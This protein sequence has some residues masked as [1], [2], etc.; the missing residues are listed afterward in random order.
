MTETEVISVKPFP[1]LSQEVNRKAYE[2][3]EKAVT[4][5]GSKKITAVTYAYALRT[6]FDSFSGLADENFINMVEE[7]KEQL[8]DAGYIETVV[9]VP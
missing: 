5:W 4:D 6:I 1:T 2:A 3:L 7:F 9:I 8:A